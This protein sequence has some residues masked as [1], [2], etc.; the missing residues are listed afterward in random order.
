MS[1]IVIFVGVCPRSSLPP[2]IDRLDLVARMLRNRPG[3]T[4]AQLAEELGVS[5]RSV[6]RDLDQLRERGI[7][8]ESSR[9]RGGGLRVPARWGM[10]TLL[11]SRDE[12]LCA[13]LAL[14]VSEKLGFPIF[15]PEIARAR[16]KIADAFPDAERRRIAPLR[17]RILIGNNASAA[18]RASYGRPDPA[19][20]RR[21]QAAFVEQRVI[22]VTY[23]KDNGE[24]SRRLLEPHALVINWPAWYL[25]AHDRL[26][27]AVR[28]FRFDR[29][30][31]VTVES[32]TFVSRP[33]DVARELLS[34]PDVHLET[35]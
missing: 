34:H 18:V 26:R 5:I 4:A 32:E 12:A 29:L 33:R 24:H 35:V 20:I 1:F 11:L 21:L 17:E 6:F 22:E 27:D 13:L 8:V 23:A 31:S 9:G 30:V 28:T 7:P 2:R 15:A 25:V 10:G 14:A 16:R 19:P 3:I